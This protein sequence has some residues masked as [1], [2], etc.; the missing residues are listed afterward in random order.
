MTDISRAELRDLRERAVDTL[1]DS[2]AS[3]LLDMDEFEQRIDRAHR[4]KTRAELD[5]LLADLGPS[6]AALVPTA[7]AA[8]SAMD[9]TSHHALTVT[10]EKT[11]DSRT[12]VAVLGGVERKGSW[13]V[14][15]RLRTYAILGGAELDL[16]EAVFAPG[17]HEIT[18]Y[19]LMGGVELIVPPSVA[20]ECDGAGILGG[21]ESVNRA[22]AEP[23]PDRPLVRVRGVAVLGGVEIS[24]RL[25]GES[26][27]DARRR[28][29][30]QLKAA[31][32][33][34]RSRNDP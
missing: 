10:S 8:S 4:A 26:K 12:L 34:L 5:E 2:F 18:I 7:G 25:P 16:R 21:F 11:D 19:A 22:P 3:D 33:Q 14:P 28:Y 24:T 15:A 17:V 29:K 32:A 31:R 23:D 1:T 13:R 9:S 27:R 20:I 30:R 6:K